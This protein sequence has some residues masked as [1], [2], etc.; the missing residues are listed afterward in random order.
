[1][2]FGDQTV[3]NLGF[4]GDRTENVLWRIDHG[5]LNGIAPRQV[6]LM[7]GTNNLTSGDSVS[8]TV[9]G[10]ATICLR[11]H[12]KLPQTKL[13]VLGLLP[14]SALREKAA[15]VDCVNFLLETRLH[16]QGW[17]QVLDVGNKFRNSD[18]SINGKLFFADGIHP[19]KD[20]Y[21]ILGENLKLFLE[22]K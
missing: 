8:D 16:P 18:G 5:E 21:A 12:E 17:V 22:K 6:I 11:I 3:A 7:I 4:G 20:G 19:N 2:A 9:A 15:E 13:L 10:I 1:M 14:C